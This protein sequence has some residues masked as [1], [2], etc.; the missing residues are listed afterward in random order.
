M[1]K[2]MK[3]VLYFGQIY[4]RNTGNITAKLIP[5]WLLENL[6]LNCYQSTTYI[7]IYPHDDKYLQLNFNQDKPLIILANF[8]KYALYKKQCRIRSRV[9]Q[10]ILLRYIYC[11]C[12]LNLPLN[13]MNKL[14]LCL[15]VLLDLF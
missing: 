15:A 11:V 4:I 12:K 5:R 2:R 6:L 14:E 7:L 13:S 3:H 10:L 8:S 9:C 1:Y